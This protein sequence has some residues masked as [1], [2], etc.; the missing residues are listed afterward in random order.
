VRVTISVSQ[1]ETSDAPR[2]QAGQTRIAIDVLTDFVVRALVSFGL[3]GKDAATVAAVLVTTDTWGTF[4]HGT[5]HLR[6]YCKKIE[7]GGI[8]P[9][10]QPDITAESAVWA[11]IEGHHAIGMVP[12]CF[13]MQTA[14]AKAREAGLGFTTVAGGGHFG[15]AG[16]YANLAAQQGMIGIAMS[17]SDPNMTV[18]GG[19]GHV[20]GNN[21]FSYAIPNGDEPPVFLDI[22]LSV[23]A[24]SKVLSAKKRGETIPADWI[25]DDEG[26]PTSDTR[27][28]PDTGSLLP[29]A[30][31]KGYGL[32]F[33]IEAIA[34]I[35][36]GA[37]C[38]RDI[39]SWLLDL[40]SRP[41][42]GHAF[43]A[44]NVAAFAAPQEFAERT[45]RAVL[46][47]RE[48]PRAKGAGRIYLPGEMEW[49][50]RA[51]ALEHGIPLPANVI[52]DLQLLAG[53]I[54]ADPGELFR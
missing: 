45:R 38:V 40:P 36:G 43:L 12:A 30:G 10:A 18:P 13:A 22:A 24:A 19:R 6:N 47:I 3:S 26:V 4:S 53:E 17:N 54:G 39:P 21:P 48:A 27:H 44:I 25:V 46:A 2:S 11:K 51:D 31:H 52:A 14:I 20:I 37:A 34:G 1:V 42:L 15:A 9:H 33:M 5:N 50:R 23:V 16:Y 49:Q 41:N 7:A 32:A 8:D 35:L 29:M 28:Y